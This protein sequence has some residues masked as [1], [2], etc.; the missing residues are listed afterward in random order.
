MAYIDVYHS[1]NPPFLKGVWVSKFSQQ[2]GVQILLIT[3]EG[4]VKKGCTLPLIFVLTNPFQPYL[5]L[6]EWW[7]V[8]SLF[9]PYVSWEELS[10]TESDQQICDFYNQLFNQCNTDSCC[11]H[12]TGGV[13]IY[14]FGCVSRLKP[15]C[16]VCLY[17]FVGVISNQNT[18]KKHVMC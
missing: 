18:S 13:N 14:L 11:E 8:F 6:S 12:I 2:V 5:L 16:A 15:V 1:W 3:R 9:T 7:C 10:L 17:L 4:L